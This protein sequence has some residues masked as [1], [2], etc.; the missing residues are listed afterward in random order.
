MFKNYNK[1]NNHISHLSASS[2]SLWRSL[3]SLG[4]GIQFG[5]GLFDL[6]L[7]SFYFLILFCNM[8]VLTFKLSEQILIGVFKF[9]DFVDAILVLG[10]HLCADMRKLV[11]EMGLEVLG[12]ILQF[13][14]F[15]LIAALTAIFSLLF[16]VVGTTRWSSTGSS[17]LVC[18]FLASCILISIGTR[19]GVPE[20]CQPTIDICIVPEEFI[21]IDMSSM[22]KL[23]NLAFLM[24]FNQNHLSSMPLTDLGFQTLGHERMLLHDIDPS[25]LPDEE[26]VT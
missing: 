12:V 13:V 20:H 21:L 3:I 5:F 19:C 17:F 14:V 15:I 2:F 23:L 7:Q 4:F 25:A 6:G 26:A 1:R 24:S 8:L 11:L 10:E 18:S 9:I 22:L 16:D